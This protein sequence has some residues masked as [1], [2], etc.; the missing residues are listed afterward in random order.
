MTDSVTTGTRNRN[1][2][3][4][5]STFV[6]NDHELEFG[7]CTF[8]LL[9]REIRDTHHKI[10]PH[11]ALLRNGNLL[12]LAGQPLVPR[13]NFVSPGRNVRDAIRAFAIRR[14]KEWI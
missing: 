4:G 8:T 3:T 14:G 2:S 13:L 9:L 7:L 6:W 11:L 1:V 5:I 12:H 10:H